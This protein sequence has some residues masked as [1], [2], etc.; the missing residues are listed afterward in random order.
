MDDFLLGAC[1]EHST[2][3]GG[4]VWCSDVINMAGT[5]AI[6]YAHVTRIPR[7]DRLLSEATAW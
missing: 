2:F 1:S 3:K 5:Q 6:S 4:V 7:D